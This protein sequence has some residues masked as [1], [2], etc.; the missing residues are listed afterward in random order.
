[1]ICYCMITNYRKWQVHMRVLQRGLGRD[2]GKEV[3]V[4]GDALNT[5]REMKVK[6]IPVWTIEVYGEKCER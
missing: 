2:A 5:G 4:R 3:F 6:N 1:M